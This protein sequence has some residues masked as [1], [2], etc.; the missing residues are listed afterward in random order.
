MMDAGETGNSGTQ[1][2]DEEEEALLLVCDECNFQIAH[3]WCAGFKQIPQEDEDWF[4]QNCSA[5]RRRMEQ[6]EK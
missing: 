6:I 3:Y 1:Q 4:C 2:Q 5:E